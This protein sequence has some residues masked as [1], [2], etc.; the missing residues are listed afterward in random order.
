MDDTI[1]LNISTIANAN[2]EHIPAQDGVTPNGR[3]L[4]KVDVT[5][6]LRAHID[7]CARGNLGKNAPKR[8]DHVFREIVAQTS[9]PI[10]QPQVFR[11]S[12]TFSVECDLSAG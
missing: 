10:D 7:I 12:I 9:A 4:A 5:N 8:S 6:Y 11:P 1:I 2:V 3:L